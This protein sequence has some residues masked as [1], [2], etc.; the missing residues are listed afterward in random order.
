MN[1]ARFIDAR[2]FGDARGFGGFGA[3]DIAALA[4]FAV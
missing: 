1:T 4:W 2:D 3:A